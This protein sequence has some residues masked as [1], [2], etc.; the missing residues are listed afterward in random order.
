MLSSIYYIHLA[1]MLT[2]SQLLELHQPPVSISDPTGTGA[3]DGSNPLSGVLGSMFG[4]SPEAR[5]ARLEE[6]SRSA[7]DLTGLIKK[8]KPISRIEVRMPPLEEP[9]QSNGKRKAEAVEEVEPLTSSK[10]ARVEDA[11]E[12]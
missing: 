7:N 8:K 9:A 4:E 10:K 6:A 3:I 11:S 1:T 12:P 5:K 2:T